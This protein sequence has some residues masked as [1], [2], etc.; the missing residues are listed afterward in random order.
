M[1]SELYLASAPIQGFPWMFYSCSFVHFSSCTFL[2]HSTLEP[3]NKDLQLFS[4]FC[5]TLL[6]LWC[7]WT[8]N[9][10]RRRACTPERTLAHTHTCQSQLF[11]LYIW[12]CG[13]PAWVALYLLCGFQSLIA[14]PKRTGVFSWLFLYPY[15]PRGFQLGTPSSLNMLARP[16]AVWVGDKG[17][18]QSMDL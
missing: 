15:L 6:N 16:M 10:V 8:Q 12:H 13:R 3:L 1:T 7:Y 4:Y 11:L 14:P 2:M 5:L 17:W 18:D 9:A